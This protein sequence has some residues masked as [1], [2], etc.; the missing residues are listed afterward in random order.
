MLDS[1]GSPRTVDDV[2]SGRLR[3]TL[4][5][6]V[7]DLPVRSIAS[8]RRWVESLDAGMGSLLR[9]VS[10]AGEDYQAIASA[11]MGVGAEELLDLV[12]A[13]DE[14]HVLPSKDDLEEVVKPHEALLAV[15]GIRRVQ[16]PLADAGLA[17]ASSAIAGMP[18]PEPTS[19]PRTNG[20]S[21]RR[22]SSTKR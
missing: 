4:G 2:L 13:Y 10:A 5:G 19:S 15:V 6:E 16:N 20:T 11:L 17:A 1:F 9:A 8:N 7:Y 22:K 21:H 12:V 3:V 14:S 18:S